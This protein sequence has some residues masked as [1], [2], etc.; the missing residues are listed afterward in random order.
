MTEIF[1][2]AKPHHDDKKESL[3]STLNEMEEEEFPEEIIRDT[4][5][6]KML[7]RAKVDILLAKAQISQDDLL[8][9]LCD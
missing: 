7:M 3:R 1:N 5:I 9:L 2:L 4:I 6:N 8:S